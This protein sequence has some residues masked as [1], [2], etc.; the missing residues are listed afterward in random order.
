M[1]QIDE[2]K[3]RV[4]RV[5]LGE[6]RRNVIAVLGRPSPKSGDNS[7]SYPGLG[8]GLLDG[9]VVSI[10]TDDPGAATIKVLRVG[11]PLSAARALYRRAAHCVPNT[12]DKTAKHP[13]CKITVPAGALLLQGDPIRTMQLVRGS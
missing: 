1:L 7:L 3:G 12:P 6:T 10:L 11:D 8:I 2:I 13:H 9:R 5:V 4:G